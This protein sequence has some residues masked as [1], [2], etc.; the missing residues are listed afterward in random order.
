V[1]QN[2]RLTFL[3]HHLVDLMDFLD[4]KKVRIPEQFRR[5]LPE[6]AAIPAQH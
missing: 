4:E 1:E 2:V 3:Q 5:R 6:A